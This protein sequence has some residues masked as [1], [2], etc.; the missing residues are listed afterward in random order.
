LRTFSTPNA[1]KERLL[2]F[3][4]RNQPI[5]FDISLSGKISNIPDGNTRLY[6]ALKYGIDPKDISTVY[7]LPSAQKVA[8]SLEQ[9]LAAA[10]KLRSG[11]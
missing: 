5:E 9:A 4:N 10:N 11:T 6:A 1:N 2:A 7:R 3:I 8:G